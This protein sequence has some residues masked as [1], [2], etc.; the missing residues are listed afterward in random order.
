[1]DYFNSNLL[2]ILGQAEQIQKFVP[3][4]EA[5]V[6]KYAMFNTKLLSWMVA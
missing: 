5:E 4:K 1:M 6:I 3:K 2:K